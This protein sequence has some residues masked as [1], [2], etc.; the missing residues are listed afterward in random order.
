MEPVQLMATVPG[1]EY[2]HVMTITQVAYL[3]RKPKVYEMVLPLKTLNSDAPQSAVS[4]PFLS[5]YCLFVVG[6]VWYDLL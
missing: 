3:Q 4:F 6:L 5:F 1:T 2:S